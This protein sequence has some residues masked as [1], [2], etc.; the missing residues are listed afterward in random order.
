V[1]WK[2]KSID[3]LDMMDTS[4]GNSSASELGSPTSLESPAGGLK[5]SGKLVTVSP[6][7]NKASSYTKPD[8]HYCK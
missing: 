5:K 4:S 2:N 6:T 7:M 3:L 1:N 8:V